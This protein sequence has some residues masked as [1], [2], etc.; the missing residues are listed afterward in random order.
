MKVTIITPTYNSIKFLKNN[1]LSVANQSYNQ[2]EHI[3][4]DNCSI[5][6]TVELAKCFGHV[7][8]IISEKDKGIFNAMNKG[9]SNATGDII[10]ILNSDDYLANENTIAT[11]VSEFEANKADAVYGNLIYLKNNDPQK[12]QRVWIAGGYEC[13]LFFTGWMFPHPTFYVKREVYDKFGK[14]DESFKYAADY[15]LILRFALKYKLTISPIRDVLVYMLA[16]GNSNKDIATRI[17]VNLEDRRAWESVG[18]RPK[19]Y[20]LHLKP[21]RKL[22]Q[23]FLPY[24]NTKWLGHIPP[25]HDNTS[26]IKNND[27]HV[28]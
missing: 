16:G 11:I 17:K 7:S 8:K 22:W 12:I 1:L 24:L 2:I 5:D 25:A 4:I 9:I 13:K 3:I 15:E 23:Y 10:G 26:F 14:F 18:L 6:G 20:T 19:W 28:F 21:I 27:I